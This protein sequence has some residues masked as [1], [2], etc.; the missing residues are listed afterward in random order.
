M[1]GVDNLGN[2][3]DVQAAIGR[4]LAGGG[5]LLDRSLDAMPLDNSPI[6]INLRTGIPVVAAKGGILI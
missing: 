3:Q 4:S 6:S 5:G 1:L 2:W